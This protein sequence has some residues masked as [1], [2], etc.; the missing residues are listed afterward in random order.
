MKN[1]TLKNKLIDD[2]LD[3]LKNKSFNFILDFL[4]PEKERTEREKLSISIISNFFFAV[5]NLSI[6]FIAFYY[7]E[8]D[9]SITSFY[10]FLVI[11]FL[12]ILYMKKTETKSLELNEIKSKFLLFIRIVCA[13]FIAISF[14]NSAYYLR[15]GTAITFFFISPIFTSF[16]SVYFF[17]D[18]FR[19]Q[20]L[21]GMIICIFSLIMIVNSESKNNEKNPNSNI[22]IGS[23]WGIFCTASTVS[24]VIS[25]KYLVNEIDSNNLNY[26]LGK[27]N[28][29]IAIIVCIFSNTLFYFNFG[30]F[31]LSL[32]NGLTFW[33]A[34]YFLNISLKINN[35]IAVSCIGFLSLV[36]A[37][38]FGVIFFG[39]KLSITDILGS[40][41]IFTFNIYSILFPMKQTEVNI[42]SS[43]PE[44]DISLI[45]LEKNNK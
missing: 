32:L 22:F 35:L 43:K 13:Y 34:L 6:K 38:T 42:I 39:E 9:A 25:T 7:P 12:S 40:L 14:A 26:L 5:S 24:V 3:N 18:K 44:L 23:M 19:L 15:L 45:N 41:F 20:N 30:F 21:I 10:R 17:N 27:Y 28:S 8:A 2:Q 37:F 4:N 1:E 16:A 36:Y 31:L 29:I 11:F 33:T